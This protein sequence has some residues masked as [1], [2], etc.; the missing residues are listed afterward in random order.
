MSISLQHT[1]RAW[2]TTPYLGVRVDL[3]PLDGELRDLRNVLVLPLSLLLLQL[4]GD[5]ADGALLNALHQVRRE[6]GNLVAQPLRRDHRDLIAQT[7][8]RVEVERKAR[9]VFLDQL[10]RRPLCRLGSNTALFA[11]RGTTVSARLPT[12]SP[13]AR[14]IP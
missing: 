5:A 6:A 7:L 11:Q 9:V 13:S 10:A 14:V 12:C 3:D 8:V 1:A 2:A 4:E